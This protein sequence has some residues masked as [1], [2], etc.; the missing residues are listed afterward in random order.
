MGLRRIRQRILAAN[1]DPEPPVRDP[2]E[3][4]RRARAEQLGRVDMVEEGRVADLDALRQAHDVERPGTAED[5]PIPAEDARP[6]QH[7]E[8][9]LKGLGA[10]AVI[11]DMHAFPAGQRLLGEPTL[12]IDDH[13]I[14]AGLLGDG[15]LHLRRDAPDD[16]AAAQ[17]DNLSQ[18]QAEPTRRRVDEGELTGLHRVEVGREVAGGETLHHHGCRGSIVDRI[19]D[20]HQRSGRDRDPLRIASGC[21]DPGDALAGSY[22]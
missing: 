1:P 22:E 21:I 11:N 5:G 14:G 3:Q 6:A 13:M 4:L 2:V 9:P 15:D 20:R 19:G 17:L 16:M 18:Q 10:R 8:R 7:V 12:A